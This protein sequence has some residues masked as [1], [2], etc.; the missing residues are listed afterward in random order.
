MMMKFDDDDGGDGDNDGEH[1]WWLLLSSDE[2]YI[3][4]R[5]DVLWRFA[6][7]DVF[8]LFGID[9][10][11][12]MGRKTVSVP[13]GSIKTEALSTYLILVSTASTGGGV[14]FSAGV[15]FSTEN[16]KG[17]VLEKFIQRI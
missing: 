8:T 12:Y 11:V 14:L 4:Q 17:T 3:S 5:S 16:T 13:K 6:C 10:K 1:L 7:G 2:S 15:P 9:M